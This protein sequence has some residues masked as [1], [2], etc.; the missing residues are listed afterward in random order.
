MDITK[1]LGII[2]PQILIPDKKVNRKKWPVIACDQFTSNIDYWRKTAK[3]VGNAPST[4]HITVPEVFLNEGDIHERIEH[5]KETMKKYIEDGVLVRLPSGIVLVERE[6]PFGTRV[7]V[8]LAIDLER[9]SPDYN[10]RPLIRATEETVS[11]RIP[12]RMKIREGASLESSHVMLLLNDP[13]DAVLSSLYNNRGNY[14]KVY[15]TQLMQGGGH[16][17]GWFI[18]D[19]ETLNGFA[20]SLYKIKKR[21]K[22][23]MLFAVGDGNH[24]L[25]SAKQVWD[26]YKFEIPE[27][28]REDHPLRFALVEVVNLYDHGMSMQPIHRVIFNVET[29]TFLRELIEELNN[30]DLNAKMMYTRGSNIR[31]DEGQ[32]LYFESKNAKGRIEIGTPQH[33]LAAMDLTTAVDNLLERMPKASIDYIHGEE[34]FEN[35]TKQHSCLGFRMDALTK[36]ELFELIE[37]YGV[38]PRKVFSLG[39]AQEKRYYY[40]CRLLIKDSADKQDETEEE[41]TGSESL[42]EIE[43]SAVEEPAPEQ[44]APEKKKSIFR[45]RK[46]K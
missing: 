4:L 11:E 10:D 41:Q 1:E 23:G 24:T 31:N 2:F 40:E 30:M 9:Y 45:K 3:Q 17:K 5:A 22:D 13:E 25:A 26:K 32:N 46:K 15:D 16:V 38:L 29:P 42:T 19:E 37:E 21:S 35:L 12:P 14:P 18:E 43:P 6:T 44:D 39:E 8:M 34:D 27:A 20:D 28:E 7:G 36:S 33:K